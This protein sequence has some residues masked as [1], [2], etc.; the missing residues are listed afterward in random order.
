MPPPPDNENEEDGGEEESGEQEKDPDWLKIWALCI[1]CGIS[2]S[3]WENITFPKI[4][5]LS[6]ANRLD[7]ELQLAMHGCK[8][9]KKPKKAKKLSDLGLFAP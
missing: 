8:V 2:D 7:Q 3:E 9:N 4:Y 6:S 5:A 1:K